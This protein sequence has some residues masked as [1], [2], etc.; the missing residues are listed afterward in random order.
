MNDADF[1]MMAGESIFSIADDLLK[2]QAALI[3]NQNILIVKL[4][5]R[6]AWLESKTINDE[7]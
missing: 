4:L 2:A 1:K 7:H 5:D 3:Q 6:V